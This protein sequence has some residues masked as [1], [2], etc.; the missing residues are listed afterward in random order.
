M[1][2]GIAAAVGIIALI[3]GVAGGFFAMGGNT[4]GDTGAPAE[5]AGLSG[6]YTLGHVAPL[7]GDLSQYGNDGIAAARL[8]EADFN[9]YLESLGAE[10][11]LA[12]AHEDTQTN[13]A[14]ALDRITSLKARGV[15]AA[16]VYS[17]AAVNS[18]K[19]Y[20]DANGMTVISG[21]S[22]A[23]QLAVAGDGVFRLV[24][25]DTRQGPALAAL[26]AGSGIEAIVP[27]W[28][29]DT[30]GTGLEESAREAFEALGGTVAEGVPYNPESPALSVSASVLAE[31]VEALVAEHGAERV[32]V[33]SISFAETLEIMQEASAHDALDGVAWFCTDG[34]T[35]NTNLLA[36]PIGLAFAETTRLRGTQPAAADTAQ[37]ADVEA[38]LVEELGRIPNT[39]S[40]GVYDAVWLFGK[41]VLESGS[42]SPEA[43]R[44]ALPLVASVHS[45]AVGHTELNEAGDLDSADYSIWG[46][47]DGEWRVV[48]TY[49]AA[50]GAVVPA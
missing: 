50:S 16:I 47:E 11:R 7:S 33:L 26:M 19:G 18:I 8:A 23:P 12:L 35:G 10:W 48:A 42:D 21:T 29:S 39:Y 37:R 36:D 44:A 6:T 46:V 14:L 30:W 2:S 43:I 49:M 4:I 34:I 25:D 9:E 41:S 40:F 17:S 1:A 27:V 22:T 15:N 32:A 13:P 38:R 24:P 20:V 31:R 28:R 45:G 5:R 3:A